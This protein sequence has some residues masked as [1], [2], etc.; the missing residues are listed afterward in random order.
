V[1][2]KEIVSIGPD[3][4]HQVRTPCSGKTVNSNGERFAVGKDTG[5]RGRPHLP[6]Y[7]SRSPGNM[8]DVMA[9]NPATMKKTP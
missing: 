9:G 5:S 6:N 1:S 8:Q 7:S 3:K 4:E 2:A